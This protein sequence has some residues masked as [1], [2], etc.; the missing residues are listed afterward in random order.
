MLDEAAIA[1]VR[2]WV[3]RPARSNGKPIATWV[4]VPV[5]FAFK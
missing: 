2:Q 3:F 4:A 5:R 1:A